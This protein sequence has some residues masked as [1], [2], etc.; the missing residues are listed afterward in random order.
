M[1]FPLGWKSDTA[2]EIAMAANGVACISDSL[3]S[4][5]MSGINISSN[6]ERDSVKDAEK[7]DAIVQFDS[8]LSE[9]IGD[10]KMLMI[11]RNRLEGEARS[12]Y[13]TLDRK[14]FSRLFKRMCKDGW[15]RTVRNRLSFLW[16]WLV[17]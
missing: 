7:L 1:R 15:F 17:V 4:F 9:R 14:T 3:F 13:W 12:Y 5:R 11:F 16:G 2:T 6:Q 10:K 8:W